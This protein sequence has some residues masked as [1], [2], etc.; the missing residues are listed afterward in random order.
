VFC[1]IL[2]C[3][4]ALSIGGPAA[5][6]QVAPPT[7]AQAQ[8]RPD[9]AQAEQKARIHAFAGFLKDAVQV[10]GQ[11]LALW[12]LQVDPTVTLAP[13][14]G[15]A[16]MDFPTP[17]GGIVYTVQ[18]A[19]ILGSQLFQFALERSA[20]P[21]AATVSAAGVVP[22]DP[23]GPVKGIA[24][25]PTMNLDQRYSDLIRES[26]IDAMLDSSVMLP[27]K[28]GQSLSVVVVPLD[29]AVTNPLYFNQSR[30]LILS[31]KGEILTALRSGKMTRDEARQKIQDVR[32]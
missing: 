28:D 4:V 30:K 10:A 2:V 1:R 26:L 24:V 32:F 20:R 23:M 8:V 27:V 17:E 13:A 29:V 19:E 11:K 14:Q 16:I 15:P 7:P 5:A 3:S 9:P 25:P 12:A 21:N 22:A 18:I 31:I 6:Q